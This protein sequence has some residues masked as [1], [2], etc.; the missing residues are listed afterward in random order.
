MWF[1]FFPGEYVEKVRP[2]LAYIHILKSE[3]AEHIGKKLD[4]GAPIRSVYVN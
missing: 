4:S 3:T 2:V 1:F